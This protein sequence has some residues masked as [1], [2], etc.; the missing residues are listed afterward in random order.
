MQPSARNAFYRMITC[1]SREFRL[2]PTQPLL[3][4]HSIPY[5][6]EDHLNYIIDDEDDDIDDNEGEEEDYPKYHYAESIENSS[7]M[8]FNHNSIC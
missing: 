7:V 5:L 3:F 6:S 1:Q 4:H 2:L 8:I